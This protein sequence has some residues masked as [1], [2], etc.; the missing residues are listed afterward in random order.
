MLSKKASVDRHVN[1]SLTTSNFIAESITMNRKARMLKL[2]K[3]AV[4]VEIIAGNI[5]F[6]VHTHLGIKLMAEVFT[7]SDHN[8]SSSPE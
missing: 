6:R 3:R 8:Y 1:Y 4:T 5:T 7:K 2:R